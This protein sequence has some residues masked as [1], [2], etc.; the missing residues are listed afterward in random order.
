MRQVLP[1]IYL[2]EGLRVAHVYVL[3]SEEGL[4]LIDSGTP[5]EADKIVKQIEGADYALSDIRAIVM[6]HAHSDHTGCMAELARRSGAQVL[7]HRDEVDYLEQTASLPYKTLMQRLIFGMS[8]RVLSRFVP[9]KVDRSLKDGDVVETLG[10]L[11]VIHVPGHT[12]GSIAL[13]QPERRVLFCGD[14]IFNQL[15]VG[16]KQGV[17]FPPAIVC[18]D[19]SQARVSTRKLAALP[20]EV[21]CFGHGEPI[22]ERA[23]ERMRAALGVAD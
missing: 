19:L 3:T 1:N 6:T 5:G 7:A 23:G 10:G 21:V 2:V 15:P 18:V 22:L 11:R 17:R 13:Y 16:G 9:C 4:T 14:A 20:T 12:P 8:E